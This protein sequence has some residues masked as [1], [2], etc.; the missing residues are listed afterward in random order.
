MCHMSVS[1][2][3][4]FI[5]NRTPQ[6]IKLQHRPVRE[7]YP[8][9][10]FPS[11]IQDSVHAIDRWFK[12][13]AKTISGDTDVGDRT[14]EIAEVVGL[15]EG[16]VH[17]DQAWVARYT[18]DPNIGQFT[19]YVFFPEKGKEQ[20]TPQDILEIVCGIASAP[21]VVT[22]LPK[23]SSVTREKAQVRWLEKNG[24]ALNPYGLNNNSIHNGAPPIFPNRGLTIEN[25]GE[26]DIAEH[27][28]GP[29]AVIAALLES[30]SVTVPQIS[31]RGSSAK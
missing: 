25:S 8:Q 14:A 21:L 29:Q 1:S 23:I 30:I 9:A 7:I 19:S 18:I 26:V 13:H 20:P 6:E 12:K 24:E 15:P 5:L 31:L 28:H 11:Q 16:P 4:R 3:E 17:F 22:I 10:S 2:S 27:S